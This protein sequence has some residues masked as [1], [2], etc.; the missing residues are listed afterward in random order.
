MVIRP[1]NRGQISFFSLLTILLLILALLALHVSAILIET[2]IDQVD[3][4]GSQTYT[5]KFEKTNRSAILSLNTIGFANGTGVYVAEF[6]VSVAFFDEGDFRLRVWDG[7]TNNY[8]GSYDQEL[9]RNIKTRK[10]VVSPNPE[11][12]LVRS[13]IEVTN[14]QADLIYRTITFSY[15]YD[16]DAVYIPPHEQRE[17]GISYEEHQEA[18]RKQQLRDGVLWSGWAVA[19]IFA[20]VKLVKRLN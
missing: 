5:F 18:I 9:G 20:L 2:P 7:E 17:A 4:G 8:V 6:I 10:F 3:T 19:S 14:E 15:Y 13:K 12:G 16:G 11:S 1:K